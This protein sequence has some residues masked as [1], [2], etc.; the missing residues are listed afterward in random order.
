MEFIL[1]LTTLW[2]VQLLAVISPGQSFVITSK[3]ALGSGR[4]AGVATAIGMGLGSIVWAVAAIAGLALVL[5]RMAWLYG[6]LKFAGGLYLLFFAWRI[7]S[8]SDRSPDL[9][10][11]TQAEVSIWRALVVGFLTQIANPKVV[12][13]FGSIFFALLPPNAPWWV[14]AAS[15]AIVFCNEVVWFTTVALA[16]S[17]ERSRLVY[18]QGKVWIDRFMA[19]ALGSIGAKLVVDALKPVDAAS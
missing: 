16:F 17:I 4:I 5:E 14:Y 8:H 18:V 2:V 1:P 15:V 13:F 10:S 7:W 9:A 11:Q 19:L 12:V 6:L 3:M